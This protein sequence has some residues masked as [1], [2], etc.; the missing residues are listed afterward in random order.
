MGGWCK[1]ATNPVSSVVN[2]LVTYQE[3]ILIIHGTVTQKCAARL[4]TL[5]F[6]HCLFVLGTLVKHYT[7]AAFL[8]IYSFRFTLSCSQ[9][10][11]HQCVKPKLSRMQVA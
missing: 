10:H 5:N 3:L 9:R 1:L 2:V 6:I 11:S 7:T 8:R 4:I